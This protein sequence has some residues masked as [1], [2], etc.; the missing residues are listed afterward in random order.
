ME[1][2]GGFGLVGEEQL[3]LVFLDAGGLQ[4]LCEA[5][6]L[7]QREVGSLCVLSMGGSSIG[8]LS[9]DFGNGCGQIENTLLGG[10]GA[11]LEFGGLQIEG[12]EFHG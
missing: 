6:D 3:G 11:G 12:G 8:Y 10:L 4:L 7:Q 5:L 1:L 9:L 2:A